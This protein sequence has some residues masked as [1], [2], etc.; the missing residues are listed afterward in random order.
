MSIKK[1]IVIIGGGAAGMTAAIAAAKENPKLSV[2]I[3]EQKEIPGKKILS[4]GNGRCNFTNAYMDV[5]CF[6]SENPEHIERV[7]GQFN[8][9]GTLA[10]FEGLGIVWKSKN[11]YYYP[12]SE[13][14]SAILDALTRAVKNARVEVKTGVSVTKIERFSKKFCIHI[15]DSKTTLEAAYVIL[16]TGGKAAK[17]LGSDGSGYA[18]AKGLG[19]SVVPVVPA[20]VQLRT[21][22]HSLLKASGVRT[23]AKVSI[24]ARE[25]KSDKTHT[26]AVC[27][28][29][30]TGELQITAYGI[31]GIPVFQVSRHA[32]RALY[33]KKRVE[34]RIDF[35][36]EYETFEEAEQFLKRRVFGHENDT[37]SD[38][39]FG[40]FN[41][42][43]IP[44]FLKC[45]GLR[46]NDKVSVLVG[47]KM[48]KLVRSIKNLHLEV[49]DTNGFDA[50]QVCAG[51]VRLDEI[52]PG[53]MESL[54][55]EGLYLAGELLDVDGICGGYN[56]QWAWASGYLAGENAAKKRRA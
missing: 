42:K 4:T 41:R 25:I 51:G 47:E 26:D 22:K 32:A 43:L 35:L 39:L 48:M 10:F 55:C 54:C 18:L 49:L 30:D 52:N 5:S 53:T 2:C 6:H 45:A 19:H 11:G 23:D 20:L 31:S 7:L 50:A 46:E 1:D 12:R 27:L 36:P 21:N 28:G 29:S 40:I 24:Y 44:C 3:L 16:T 8:T 15:K 38:F 17:V 33:E 9:A 37:V 56:L 13:Q 34:A 14:A